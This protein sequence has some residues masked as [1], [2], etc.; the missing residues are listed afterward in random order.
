MEA[1]ESVGVDL[2]RLQDEG[3]QLVIADLTFATGDRR[4]PTTA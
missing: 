4:W 2:S 3:W 1:L